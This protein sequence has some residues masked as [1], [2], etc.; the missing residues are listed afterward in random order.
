VPETGSTADVVRLGLHQWLGVATGSLLD[1]S[2]HRVPLESHWACRGVL[3]GR[4]SSWY[5][6]KLRGTR[7]SGEPVCHWTDE[8]NLKQ[9]R[10]QEPCA[11][12]AS[13]ADEP[14]L[15]CQFT[16]ILAPG[17][18]DARLTLITVGIECLAVVCWWSD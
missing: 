9:T 1:E 2:L 8:Y 15:L 17:G 13:L 7:A 10:L 5:L 11:Q 4:R 12:R 16:T 6:N 3:W 18:D 14:V